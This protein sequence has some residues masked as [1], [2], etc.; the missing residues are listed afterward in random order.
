VN[1]LPR[2][3]ALA[4]LI[5]VPCSVR[6]AEVSIEDITVPIGTASVDV[7]ILIAPSSASEMIG[8]MNIFFGAG[9]PA[10]TIPILNTGTEFDGSIWESGEFFGIPGTPTSHLAKGAIAMLGPLEIVPDGVLVTYTLNTSSLPAGN[11][12][13]DPDFEEDDAGTDATDGSID[14]VPLDLTFVNGILRIQAMQLLNGDYNG[15]GTVEQADLD[16]VLLNWGAP[17]EPVPNGWTNDL[18]EGNIDQA[19]LDG[20]LLNWGNM[21]NQMAAASVPEPAT[22]ALAGVLAVIAMRLRVRRHHS[23]TAK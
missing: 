6:A 20:V 14:P 10:D 7:P 21:G 16:L 15:N 19:E 4:L 18:P 17:A 8:A 11:Y 13:L 9:M 1:K 3:L 22:L 12:V 2:S 23:I 5:S